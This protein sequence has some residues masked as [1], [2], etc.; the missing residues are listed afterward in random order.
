MELKGIDKCRVILFLCY[1]FDDVM[2]MEKIEGGNDR[3]KY[4][5]SGVTEDY[6]AYIA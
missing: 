2:K 3:E 6:Y 4:R 1:N 5:L